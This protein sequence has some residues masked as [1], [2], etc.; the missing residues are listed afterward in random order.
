MKKILVLHTGGTIAMSKN[1]QGAVAPT[2]TNP[3]MAF[4]QLSTADYT[5]TAESVFNLPSSHITPAHMLTLS[6]HV[7]Q[8]LTTDIDG[9]VITHGT[10]TLEE[11][12]YFL[13][14]VIATNVPIVLT[15]AMRSSNEVGSDGLHNLQTAI[16]TAAADSAAGQGVLVVLNDEIHAARYVTKTHTTNVATFQTPLTGPLGIL[17]AGQPQFFQHLS[18]SAACPITQLA[19]HVFL[20]KAYAGM[21]ATLF[22]AINQLTTHGLVIEAP[23]AGNLPPETVPAIKALLAN[24]IPVVLVSRC[25]NGVAAPIYGDVGGGRQLAECGVIFC[26]GLNG[27]KARIKL[28]IAVSAGLHGPE[29]QHFM[30]NANS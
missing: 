20:L 4:D 5:V 19:T 23:G 14:L 2:D 1:K 16:A 26:Q 8:A 27:Q 13:D 21:D 7:Q 9:I 17:V 3:L 25:F 15:G 22:A 30:Q 11:T 24:Q 12:A 10:D 29:L 18:N 28:Q 6:Q